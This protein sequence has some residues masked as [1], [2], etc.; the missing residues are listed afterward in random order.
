MADDLSS[1]GFSTTA[2]VAMSTWDNT[3]IVYN[4]DDS[5]SK[6]R[7]IA[8]I[9]GGNPEIISNDGSYPTNANVIVI[10]GFDQVYY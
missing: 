6:A 8:D 5:E 9:I 4:G 1:R 2:D 7:A 10:L 3:V